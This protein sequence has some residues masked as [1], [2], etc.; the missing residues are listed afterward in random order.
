MNKNQ[1]SY[2]EILKTTSVYGGVQV[3]NIIIMIIRSKIIA[4]LLGPAGVGVHGLLMSSI[5]FIGGL[6]NFGLGISSV[7][8]VAEANSSGDNS[9]I[10]KVFTVLKRLVWITGLLGAIISIT[11]SPWLSE[12]TFGNKNYTFAF[13]WIS[14][15]LLFNQLTVARNVLLQ[16]LRKINYLAKSNLSGSLLGLTVSFPLYYFWGIDGI[17]PAIILTS[18]ASLA[19]AW[20]FSRKVKLEKIEV[21]KSETVTIGKDMLVMGFMLSISSLY[22][23]AKEYGIRAFISNISGID[24]VGLYTAGF[25]IVTTYVGMIFTVMST[26]YYPRL[27]AIAENNS[28]SRKLINQ[29]AEIAILVLAPIIVFFIIFVNWIII[30]LYSEKFIPINLM[31]QLAAIGMLF[32]ALSWSIAYIFLAKGKS[33]MFLINELSA[34]TVTLILHLTGYY[35]FGLTGVGVGFIIGYIYYSVQVA[36]ITKKYF[37]FMINAFLY[38]LIALQLI[39]SLAS[40]FIMIFITAPYNYFL[41]IPLLVISIIYSYNELNKRVDLKNYLHKIIKKN[42]K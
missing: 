42:D 15:A 20:Y 25:A 12:I 35:F 27:S 6:T 28:K 30:I 33:K 41:A 13:I 23:L 21:S 31:M 18:L 5:N 38:K 39:L 7:R 26:D 22:V 10:S 34:G 40:F 32:K 36:I 3:F 19:R 24:E 2:R 37:N 17:V 11:L 1:S 29:Q 16:G 4:I 9:K 8:N 14:L